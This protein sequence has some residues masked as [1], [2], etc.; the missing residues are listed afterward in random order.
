MINRAERHRLIATQNEILRKNCAR[1]LI[2]ALCDKIEQENKKSNI[3]T[4]EI[5]D[6]SSQSDL[7][8]WSTWNYL[9]FQ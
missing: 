5:Q 3:S 1:R 6:I 7:V 4:R 2:K 9:R 8:D